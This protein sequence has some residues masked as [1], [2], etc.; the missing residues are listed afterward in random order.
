MNGIKFDFS[1]VFHP[2]IEN[3]LTEEEINE[4]ANRVQDIV[5]TIKQKNPG[6]LSLPFTRVYIDRVLDLK[7]WIQSFESVV[8][9]GIGGSALG[10]QAL[11]TALNPLNYNTLSKEIRKTP[12][13]FIL[14]NVDPDFIA[15]VL[16]QID[17]KT[18][19]F[20]VISKSGTTAEAMANYLVARGIV[21]G[22]GLDPKEHFLFT[23]DPEKGILKKIAEEEGIKTLD[24]PPSIGGRFSVLTP[25]GLLSA[26][27]SGIDIID[28]YNGAKEMQ[29][30]VINP[31]IWENP[32]AFNALVHY[33][34]YQKGYNISVMMS[35]SNKLYLLAD[36]YRQLWAES[37]GKKY[38]LKGEVVNL[39]Q[40]PIK[41]LG[42]TD[43]HSQVQLYNEGPYDKVITFMQLE[44]FERNIKIP[45]IH[46]DL[47]E[48]SYLGGK[49]LSTLLNTELA[50]TEYA[51]TENN[52]PNLKVIF[53]QI[54]PFN[55]GQ[56][57]FA[58]EFQTAVMGNLLEIN[59]YD[60]PG[61]E[62][63][64]KVTYALM[65]RKGYEDFSI[66]VENKLK[67]KK[68]VMM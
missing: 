54:N 38:N 10:N 28:L 24:I 14:D 22:Y 56:F 21:E 50:G 66:E 27:A 20:N 45:N 61:V 29:K 37:L 33:L 15:S 59:P 52:R 17:P 55:V 65:G 36:W 60:Q 5:E 47:P 63:G 53:P 58:Y 2:N 13:I 9:L 16:D 6:F 40:T 46:C 41:A 1:N 7:T 64:K 39:G 51:L 12:K 31:N 30:R 43:Q 26:L 67:N 42:T 19:L 44:N 18:T 11:Q 4:Q 34:Y 23:T 25:V 62:L 3:G 49:N 57:I 68:Q 32:S 48:L 35:Y 8:V